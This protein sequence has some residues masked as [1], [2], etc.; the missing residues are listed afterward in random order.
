LTGAGTPYISI[1]L[2]GDELGSIA[3]HTF[4]LILKFGD[5]RPERGPRN[6]MRCMNEARQNG[7]TPAKDAAYKRSIGANQARLRASALG[8][9]DPG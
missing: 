1:T 6:G 5:L 2:A 3:A 9:F 8:L 7:E 4:I